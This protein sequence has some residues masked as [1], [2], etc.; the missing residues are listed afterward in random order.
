MYCVSQCREVKEQLVAAWFP[1]FYVYSSSG[2]VTKHGGIGRL[3][4]HRVLVS[5]MPMPHGLQRRCVHV[6]RGEASSGDIGRF[7]GREA[8]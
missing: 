2:R 5:T 6:L 8:P 1:R 3:L 7:A 4:C